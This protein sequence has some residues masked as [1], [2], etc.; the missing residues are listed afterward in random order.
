MQKCKTPNNL[1]LREK[2]NKVATV[3]CTMGYA[4]DAETIKD[5]VKHIDGVFIAEKKLKDRTDRI[6]FFADKINLA[7][8]WVPMKK[9]LKEEN[10]KDLLYL[11]YYIEELIAKLKKEVM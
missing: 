7:N 4:L 5:V 2:A 3:A 11:I 6:C 10:K 8:G 1:E 9:L